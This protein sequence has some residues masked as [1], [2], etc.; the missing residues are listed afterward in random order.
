[1]EL[2]QVLTKLYFPLANSIFDACGICQ[3]PGTQ[4]QVQVRA[5]VSRPDVLESVH[6]EEPLVLPPS[7]GYTDAQ[8]HTQQNITCVTSTALPDTVSRGNRSL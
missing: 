2:N 3:K 8:L 7:S 6:V 1:M 4:P 5:G